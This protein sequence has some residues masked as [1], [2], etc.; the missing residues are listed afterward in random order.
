MGTVLKSGHGGKNLRNH[1]TSFTLMYLPPKHNPCSSAKIHPLTPATWDLKETFH[2]L[3]KI[4]AYCRKK[5]S[6]IPAHFF[7]YINISK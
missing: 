6:S 4:H 7:Y 2:E 1:A 5:K 3:G